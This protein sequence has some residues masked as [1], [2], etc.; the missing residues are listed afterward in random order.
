MRLA[1]ANLTGGGLSGG[2]MK[3]MRYL[4]P[5]LQNH[6]S[7]NEVKIYISSK[8]ADLTMLGDKDLNTWPEYDWI[9]GYPW[10][11]REMRAF[12]PDAI[13]VPNSIWFNFGNI[14]SVIEVRNMEALIQ[15]VGKNKISI[16]IKNLLRREMTR[17]ACQNA[18]RIIAVSQ[19]VHKYL[20]DRW[21]I[22]SRKIGIIHH[23][24]ESPVSSTKT[25]KPILLGNLPVDQF[26]F[27]AGSLVHYRGLEDI[28]RAFN[29]LKERCPSQKLLIAGQSCR[30]TFGYEKQMKQLVDKFGLASRVIWLGHLTQ[31]EMAW[32]FYNCEAFVMTSRIEACPNIALE[33]LSYG[34]INISTSNPP[35]PE[36]FSDGA[37]YYNANSPEDLL[38]R[39]IY[40]SNLTSINKE[41][42]RTKARNL[43]K[44]YSW[45]MVA[46]KTVENFMQAI[47][48]PEPFV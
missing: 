17:Y 24:I 2:G 19:F 41:S 14:P 10:L 43:S 5:C 21:H 42:M 12:A 11:R 16:G 32:C 9:K 22:P 47:K 35:M 13:F 36:I 6:P 3:T 34:C 38:D 31:A 1:I 39:I 15:P 28:I 27:T 18:T 7:V 44:Q 25:L 29:K 30:G 8:V 20:V 23:G 45:S 37:L 4:I 26:F 46:K 40:I 33:A 48:H